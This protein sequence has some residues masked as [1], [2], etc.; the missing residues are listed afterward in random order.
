MEDLPLQP[1]YLEKGVALHAAHMCHQLSPKET[2]KYWTNDARLIMGQEILCT[3][4]TPNEE[5]FIALEPM[6]LF[7]WKSK[8]G[9][10]VSLPFIKS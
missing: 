2:E 7:C 10:S 1:K 6:R 3:L 8:T 5:L 4:T 9:V